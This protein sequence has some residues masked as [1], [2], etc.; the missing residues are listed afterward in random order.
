[1]ENKVEPLAGKTKNQKRKIHYLEVVKGGKSDPC[2]KKT[3][4][5]NVKLQIFS[6]PMHPLLM[7]MRT[8]GS[9]VITLPSEIILK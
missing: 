1:V 9:L 3:S 6:S 8:L 4:A 5:L 2:S 7:S